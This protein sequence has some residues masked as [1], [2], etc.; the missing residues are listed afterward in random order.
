VG[1]EI[2]RKLGLLGDG[3]PDQILGLL[4]EGGQV[5]GQTLPIRASRLM[6]GA[7][8]KERTCPDFSV[9]SAPSSVSRRLPLSVR[10][11]SAAR[12]SASATERSTTSGRCHISQK[13]SFGVE[14]LSPLVD[15][16]QPVADRAQDRLDARRLA[17]RSLAR[18]FELGVV[19]KP[20]A[21]PIGARPAA[22]NRGRVDPQPSTPSRGRETDRPTLGGRVA[23]E[24]LRAKGLAGRLDPSALEALRHLPREQ[25]DE[26]R[27]RFHLLDPHE[28]QGGRVRSQEPAVAVEDGD[29]VAIVVHPVVEGESAHREQP[30]VEDSEEPQRE[31]DGKPDQSG[32]VSE[33]QHPGHV[34]EIRDQRRERRPEEN[35]DVGLSTG[36]AP[37]LAP[38]P[39]HERKR[40]EHERVPVERLQIPEAPVEVGAAEYGHEE[41]PVPGIGQEHDPAERG[42][43]QRPILHRRSRPAWPRPVV[44]G[45]IDGERPPER[46]VEEDSGI[47]H[48]EENPV[49]LGSAGEEGRAELATRP[50]EP[51]EG[52]PQP[53]RLEGTR[54]A[55]PP[56]E[57]G[58]R[59][60]EKHRGRGQKESQA[61]SIRDRICRRAD[62]DARDRLS[63]SIK[64]LTRSGRAG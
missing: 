45:D 46:S 62:R 58:E 2:G 33:P 37:L 63:Q 55:A 28:T 20:E 27:P 35:G 31:A 38:G 5:E 52:E 6:S 39:S 11:A 7:V 24:E 15:H 25:G 40:S 61:H 36:G 16:E 53:E 9:T 50:R 19:A 22:G 10:A 17:R 47:E 3:A 57:A 48:D 18:L 30:L 26:V 21:E 23:I 32:I 49:G 1:R 12:R 42:E 41:R 8:T 29:S 54:R 44:G 59:R 34:E 60:P 64:R 13:R 51:R 14:E 4:D 56:H 43:R